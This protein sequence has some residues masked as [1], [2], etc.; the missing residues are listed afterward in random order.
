MAPTD[1]VISDSKNRFANDRV[2]I[3]GGASGIGL[4]IA[5]SFAS[6]GALVALVDVNETQLDVAVRTIGTGATGYVCDISSWS[7]Q[8]D[9]FEKV[10]ATIG[11]PTIVCLNAG[12]DPELAISNPSSSAECKKR[13]VQYNYLAPE[14]DESDDDKKSMPTTTTGLKKPPSNI[15]DVNFYGVLYGIKL[16]SHYMGENGGRIIVTGSAASYV[17]F[18]YQDIYVAS[19]H[20]ILGLV[21]ATA[22]RPQES[23]GRHRPVSLSMV[24]PWLTDTPLTRANSV[25][26]GGAQALS[27]TTSSSSDVAQAVLQLSTMDHTRCHGR[28]LW[29]RGST[30]VEVEES[31]EAWLGTL[32]KSEMEVKQLGVPDLAK[33]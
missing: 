14:L 19:K 18:P 17:G 13:L 8:R 27:P 25:L 29:V 24:A 22:K 2:I 15:L 20:A 5:M 1:Q 32:G 33:L 11:P 3:T 26:G 23:S 28:C 4:A 9:L 31:Y 21:R 6:Y 12:I 7:E 16:A 10:T 30:V